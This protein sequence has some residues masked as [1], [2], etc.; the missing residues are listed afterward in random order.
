MCGA[1]TNQ[2]ANPH[3]VL[4]LCLCLQ[5]VHKTEAK[6]QVKGKVKARLVAALEA[7]PQAACQCSDSL[8]L[9]TLY[10]LQDAHK[11]EAKLQ[12]GGK[13]EAKLMADAKP[14]AHPVTDADKSK[15]GTESQ[16]EGDG[17][18][19][20]GSEGDNGDNVSAGSA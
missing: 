15:T 9:F 6:L 14:E 18:N 3:A 1:A 13:V 19:G 5:D 7:Q 12:V 20:G 8:A 10:C 11:T 4:T 2:Y 17:H 16:K